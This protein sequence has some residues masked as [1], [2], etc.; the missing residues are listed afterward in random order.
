MIRRCGPA[1]HAS[2]QTR[3][4]AAV[5]VPYDSTAPSIGTSISAARMRT[6]GSP[7]Q[8]PS[9]PPKE[10]ACC[11]TWTSVMG[12][13]IP[14]CHAPRRWSS[15][16]LPSDSARVR[17]SADISASIARASNTL[18]WARGSARAACMASDSPTGPAP[19]TARRIARSI[20][21]A[22]S[23]CGC[24]VVFTAG[25]SQA[26]SVRGLIV[27]PVVL[28]APGA[29]QPRIKASISSGSTGASRLISSQPL[30]LSVTTASSSMRMPRFQ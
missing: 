17:G 16:T 30:A 2:I 15:C 18:I 9:S 27:V 6:C 21:G 23:S 8:R 10:G 5:T 4:K 22:A 28:E 14:S 29:L 13:P 25:L 19:T 12:C 7:I 26:V 11:D 3:C 20:K 1:L 24:G